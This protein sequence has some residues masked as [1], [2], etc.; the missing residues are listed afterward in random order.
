MGKQNRRLT[1][2]GKGLI[3]VAVPLF[4]QLIAI[5]VLLIQLGRSEAE[6][7][8]Q[9]DAVEAVAE[10]DRLL[11]CAYGV[12]GGL[13]A[14]AYTGN[15]YS[16]IM[17]TE[18]VRDVAHES[19]QLRE[20]LIEKS[21]IAPGV[22]D[23]LGE[24]VETSLS[25]VVIDKGEIEKRPRGH[26]LLQTAQRF[27]HL[28]HFIKAARRMARV[29][30]DQFDPRSFRPE[31]SNRSVLIAAYGS[32]VGSLVAASALAIFFT[33]GI[34]SRIGKVSENIRRYEANEPLIPPEN[35]EHNLIRE[36][37]LGELDRTFFEMADDLRIAHQR[38]EQFLALISN[39]IADPLKQLADTLARLNR[40]PV[41]N[42]DEDMKELITNASSESQRLIALTKNL[43]DTARGEETGAFV[44]KLQPSRLRDH[45]VQAISAV[46]LLSQAKSIEI[47][48][49]LDDPLLNLDRDRIIQVMVN[50]LSNSIK[51]SPPG[52]KVVVRLQEESH[53]V[54]VEVDDNGPG[55]GDEE[56][57][58]IFQSFS[59]GRSAV[60]SDTK[61]I[62]L[63][64]A[65]CKSIV[66][67]HGGRIG[68]DNGAEGGSCFW[69]TIPSERSQPLQL[70]GSSDQ[71]GD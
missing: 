41:R 45:I 17:F 27:N 19:T 69:F 70:K 52:S 23:K 20:I 53:Q 54:R 49:V 50:L 42:L 39:E 58:R 13:Y 28:N 4:L 56:K 38:K 66:E 35:N 25:K 34:E 55:I 60:A 15:P 12:V 71:G 22:L 36:D 29:A 68:I 8:R 1:I 18:R 16:N 24:D 2:T 44:L 3:L 6:I 7:N 59:R 51:Y 63:G 11:T 26:T 64:L 57:A 46:S 21:G 33:R 40:E 32:L 5:I 67:A 47:S 48:S 62:G 43:V 9:A 61:G 10:A 14:Y 65:I 37:E 30:Y 31:Q